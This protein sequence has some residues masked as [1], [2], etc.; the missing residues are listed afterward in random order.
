MKFISEGVHRRQNGNTKARQNISANDIYLG[1]SKKIPTLC[2][3]VLRIVSVINIELLNNTTWREFIPIHFSEVS[4]LKAYTVQNVDIDLY[5]G[6][7]KLT[8]Q[9]ITNSVKTN[10]I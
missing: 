1:S 9:N 8:F 3:H 5:V 7:T 4:P 6:R 10:L 2:R